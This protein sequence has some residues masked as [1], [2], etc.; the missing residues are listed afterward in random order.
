[1]S[2]PLL[3]I[4]KQEAA[5]FILLKQGLYGDYRF[6]KKQGALDYIIQAGCIQFDPVDSVGKNAELTLQSRVKGFRKKDLYTLLYRD[7]SLVDYFDKEL[8]II[9][10][11][12]WPYF[13]R[14]RDLSH[15]NGKRFEG[16]KELEEQA[17][18]YIRKHGNVSSSTLPVDGQIRWH[19]AIHWSGDWGGGP[20]KAARSVLEQLYT[21][22]ELIIH[23]KEGARKFY[24]L[25]EK[26]LSSDILKAE[27]PI[28]D[29]FE[30]IKWRIKRRIGAVGMLWNK[31]SAALLGIW[32]LDTPTRNRAFE[33]LEK[34]GAIIRIRIDGFRQDLFIL[35]SDIELFEQAKSSTGSSRCE[36]LAP[37]DPM[38]WDRAL[39]EKIFDFKYSWEIY[40]PKEKRQYGYYVLPVLLGDRLI[41][42][43]EPVLAESE[44]Q[45]KGFWLEPDIK[46]T[47]SLR[48]AIEQRLKKFARFN[49]AAYTQP[50]ISDKLRS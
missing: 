14:Y 46:Y 36:F 20:T 37:L 42:R 25:A 32:N 6:E 40:T 1:M 11:A 49:D 44:L 47:K 22:G 10:A 41:G 38:L 8:A 28:K 34:E 27:D 7:R 16:L 24:D 48:H 4:T 30:H 9:P 33:E 35:N 29:D 19:S 2:A 5:R 13:R 17:V 43:I 50:G 39:I 21:T 15:E 45:V 23:H 31:N 3:T 12:D 18:S 26:H